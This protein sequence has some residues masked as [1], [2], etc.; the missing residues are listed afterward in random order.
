MVRPATA[1]RREPRPDERER[2]DIVV[3][4]LVRV[5]ATLAVVGVLLFDAISVGTATMSVTD[6]A[7]EAA[8]VASTDW[9]AHH[10]QQSAFDAAWTAATQAN[11]T[12]TVDTHTFRVEKNGTVHLTMHRTAPTLVLRLLGPLSHWADVTGQGVGRST[13]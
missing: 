8:R 3:G 5:V 7:S 11:A 12:N 2:G 9:L 13:S 10:D 4:W 6:Q 1:A